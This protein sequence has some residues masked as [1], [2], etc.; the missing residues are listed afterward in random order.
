MVAATTRFV[1]QIKLY[2][3]LHI[4]DYFLLLACICVTAG[5]VLGYTKVGDLYW[6]EDLSLHPTRL[7]SLLVS[8]EDFVN[9]VNAYKRLSYAYPAL[10]WTAI[11]AVKFA[12][13]IFFRQLVARLRPL[14]IYWRVVLTITIISFPVCILSIY[15]GCEKWGLEASMRHKSKRRDLTNSACSCMRSTRLFQ[16]LTRAGLLRHHLGRRHRYHDYPHSNPPSLGGAHQTPPEILPRHLPF[17]EPLHGHNRL[18][19]CLGS[20]VPRQF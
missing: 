9:Q 8:E 3:R 6:T 13:L 7:A 20:H 11:F 2:R 18:S 5:T 14:I 1:L 4:D 12:Y 15:V 17:F 10:L 16:A 19:S